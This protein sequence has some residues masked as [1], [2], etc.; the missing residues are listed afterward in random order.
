LSE[1]GADLGKAGREQLH[2][3]VVEQAGRLEMVLWLPED[4]GEK[5]GAI[6]VKRLIV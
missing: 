4:L 6:I 5:L 3:V 1:T 2:L